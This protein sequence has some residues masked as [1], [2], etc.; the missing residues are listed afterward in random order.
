MEPLTSEELTLDASTVHM[1]IINLVAGDDTAES[2]IQNLM[3]HQTD[4]M[5]WTYFQDHFEVVDIY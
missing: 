2:K 3:N 5:D 4:R 1:F